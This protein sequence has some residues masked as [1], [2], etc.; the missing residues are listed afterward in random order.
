MYKDNRLVIGQAGEKEI[1]LS[2]KTMDRH[3]L[4]AGAT[5]TGKTTT[6]R[7]LAESL[8]DAGVSVFIADIKGDLSSVAESYPVNIWDVF[9]RSGMPKAAEGGEKYED[10]AL[11]L[12][13][14]VSEV[15]PIVLARMLGLNETQSQI[16]KVVFKIADDEGLLLIDSKDLRAMLNYVSENAADYAAEYGN[17]AKQSV[18]TIIRSIVALEDEGGDIFFSEPAVD[19]FDWIRTD[20]S[21]KGYIQ[22]LDCR[23]LITKPVMYSSFMLWLLSE[24]YENL[25]EVGDKDRPNIVFFFDEAHL[26][27]EG[28]PKALLEKIEQTVKLIRSKEV[29]IFFISQ[30]PAD[31]PDGVLAQL[32]CK[33]QHALH[34]YTPAEI[35]R[36]KAIADTYRANEAFDTY[37]TLTSLG[38]GEA[39]VSVLDENGVPTVVEKTKIYN[40]N[41]SGAI[42][43]DEQRMSITKASMLY[44]RYTDYLDRDSAYELLN[45]KNIEKAKALEEEKEAAARAKEEEKEA[46]ARAKAEEREAAARAK[47][48]EREAAARAKAEER[49]AA[50]KAKA[51]EKAAAAKAKETQKAIKNVVSATG[52]TIGR[53]LGKTAGKAVGGSF[54]KTLGGNIGASLGRG[55]LGTLFK[56]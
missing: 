41:T 43:S 19:I 17:I 56:K 48:E 16:L 30:S 50:A 23:K 42:L 14:T 38:I 54:G 25:P 24:L 13:T 53:E 21:Q 39:L 34:A 2:L 35:K 27:F 36:V 46:A 4:I 12:H 40:A 49:E 55:L 44:K 47:A 31:I 51:E 8:S 32:S 52:G 33:I 29:G 5:G 6:V 37:E 7:A 26:L 20:S 28:A 11:P 45:R 18:N 15:G 3:G 10:P 1:E 9:S 22:L